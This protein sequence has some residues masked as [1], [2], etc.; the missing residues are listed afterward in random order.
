M[1]ETT[2]YTIRDT[3]KII[4]EALNAIPKAKRTM[5]DPQQLYHAEPVDIGRAAVVERA[6]EIIRKDNGWSRADAVE[7]AYD[8]LLYAGNVRKWER[9]GEVCLLKYEGVARALCRKREE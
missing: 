1:E 6:I 4:G 5:A 9:V 2:D 3:S 8:S 7:L